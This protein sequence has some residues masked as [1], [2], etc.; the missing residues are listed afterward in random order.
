MGITIIRRGHQSQANASGGGSSILRYYDISPANNGGLNATLRFSHFNAELNGQDENNLLLWRSPDNINWTNQGFTSRNTPTN[1][2]EKTGIDAF[3]RWTLS[4]ISVPLPITFI[5]FNARCENEKVLLTWK[6]AQEFN[7]SHFNIE[8]STDG[9]YW[10]LIGTQPAAGNSNAERSYTSVDNNPLTGAVYRIVENDMDGHTKYTGIIRSNCDA[11]DGW[12]VWPNPVAENLWLNISVAAE[13]K[14]II[15]IV[16]S[17]GALVSMQQNNL[18]RGNNLLNVDMK[19]MAAGTY[20]V[21][22]NWDNGQMQ[23]FVK[24]VKL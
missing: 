14:I 5:V 4:T 1:Y 15:K 11:K 12:K 24:I 16:D 2:V 23:K 8:R 7:S 21:I 17:K 20:H 9:N 13:S 6:T 22:A 18:L 19:K 10:S 3:S